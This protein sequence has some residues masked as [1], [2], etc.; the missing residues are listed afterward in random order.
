M[1]RIIILIYLISVATNV[2]AQNKDTIWQDVDYKRTNQK[3]LGKTPTQYPIKPSHYI[4]LQVNELFRQLLNFSGSTSSLINP[5]TLTYTYNNT[6]GKGISL[7]VG[8]FT[9]KIVK[10]GIVND[11]TN[12]H[13][14][15]NFRVGYDKK[16]RIG[17]RW[18]AGWGID[19]LFIGGRQVIYND[20]F[21]GDTEWDGKTKGWGFGP[22]GSLLFSINERLWLGTE[23]NWYLSQQT[24]KIK[25]TTK[26]TGFVD[27]KTNRASNGNLQVPVAIFLIAKF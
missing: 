11:T 17:K 19:V 8:Y 10:E 26:Q 2:I 25:I 15:I 22:R 13:N 16:I 23:C 24:T 27:H 18:I 9:S 20:S 4:G 21:F 1:L 7:G 6:A 12:I 5:Y 3:G 14:T